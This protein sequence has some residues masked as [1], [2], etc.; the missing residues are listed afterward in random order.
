MVKASAK[1]TWAAFRKW[2][3]RRPFWGG[4][5]TI[6]AGIVVLFPPFASLKLGDIVVSLNTIGGIS[7]GLIGIVLVICGVTFWTRP[8][9]RLAAGIVALLL[10]LAAVVAANLGSLLIAT[11]LGIVGSA[12]GIAWSPRRPAVVERAPEREPEPAASGG[13]A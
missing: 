8:Q 13:E 3:H 10:S 12:L 9:F 1:S 2:R 11:L 5:C 4:L 7:A 6:L